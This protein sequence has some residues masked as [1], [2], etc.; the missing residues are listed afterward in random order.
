MENFCQELIKILG[1]FTVIVS[2]LSWLIKSVIVHYLNK[3]VENYKSQLSVIATKEIEKLKSQLQILNKE[4]EFRFIKLHE[5]RAEIISELYLKIYAA[6]VS[7]GAFELR[8]EDGDDI[9]EFEEI[10]QE[11]YDA[12]SAALTYFK[13][14]RLFLSK[15]LANKIYDILTTLELTSRSLKYPDSLRSPTLRNYRE[16]K[17]HIASVMEGLEKEFRVLLGSEGEEHLDVLN[18]S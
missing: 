7:V 4:R 17:P 1:I 12:C 5:K 14:H 2:A 10:I 9:T 11:S 3:D 13:K 8:Y 6:D 16:Q 18:K 15:G